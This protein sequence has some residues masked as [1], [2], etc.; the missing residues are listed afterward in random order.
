MYRYPLGIVVLLSFPSCVQERSDITVFLPR[1]Q[2]NSTLSLPLD[3]IAQVTFTLESFNIGNN[4]VTFILA[5]VTFLA[6]K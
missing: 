2:L 4:Y 6:N 3:F 1:P 5:T